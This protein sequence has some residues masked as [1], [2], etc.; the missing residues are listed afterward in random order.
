MQPAGYELLSRTVLAGDQHPRLARRHL[1]DQ[2]ADV[3]DLGRES[4][5]R[6]GL[7]GMGPAA[8]A[9]CGSR[10]GRG[11]IRVV[12]G[13]VDGLQQTVHVD[14]FGQKVLRTVAYGLHGRVDRGVGREGNDRNARIGNPEGGVRDDHVEGDLPA[15]DRRLGLVLGRLG[16]KTFVFQP[17]TQDVSHAF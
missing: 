2:L 3:F 12:D 1:L 7:C 4:D 13:P 11:G 9:R 5:D 16:R 8:A 17:L 10:R 6:L 14:G 15:Q